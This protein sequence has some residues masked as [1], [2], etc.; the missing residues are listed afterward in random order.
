MER[1]ATLV[2]D[3]FFSYPISSLQFL[4]SAVRGV[5][6]QMNSGLIGFIIYI[7]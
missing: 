5:N 6:V 2:L 7:L 1:N 4:S 3:F